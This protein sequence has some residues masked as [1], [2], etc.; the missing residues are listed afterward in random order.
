MTAAQ[1][2]AL[3]VPGGMVIVGNSKSTGGINIGATGAVDLSGINYSLGLAGLSGG[4]NFYNTL[5]L[6]AGSSFDL[7][8]GSSVVN[9]FSPTLDISILNGT[10]SFSSS[11]GVGGLGQP[12]NTNVGSFGASAIT[13]SVYLDNST[14]LTDTLITGAFTV[15]GANSDFNLISGGGITANSAVVVG[16][17]SFFT[18]GSGMPLGT[19][20]KACVE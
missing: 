9:G 1:L 5:S 16:G 19:Y 15:S 10:L 6:P 3:D 7:N 12:L 20:N 18:I 13:G 17:Q 11:G 4:V 14:S 8:T 2:Q